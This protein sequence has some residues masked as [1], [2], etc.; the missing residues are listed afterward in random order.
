ML[1][2]RT[3]TVALLLAIMLG[4]S[5]CKKKKPVL[6][7]V[8]ATA[9][10]ITQ[11]APQTPGPPP[12][13]NVEP[14][15]PMPTPGEVVASSAPAKPAPKPKTHIARKTI[16]PPPPEAPKKTVVENET[17]Q[18]QQDN[19]LTA[20]ISRDAAIQQRVDTVQLIN[21]TENTLR[22]ITRQLNSDEQAMVQHIRSF[23]KQSQT[24]MS[25]GDLERA[26]NLA[27]KANQLSNE[28]AKK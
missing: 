14:S 7:P 22:G 5:A 25:E 12:P 2:R 16:P 19:Q 10:T 17:T 26:K 20:S 6:P 1:L 9:P 8:Q 18:N 3:L 4:V 27:F 24:A 13:V 28:L 15:R 21:A 11:P 23:I